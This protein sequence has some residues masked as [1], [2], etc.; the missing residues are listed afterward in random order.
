M[1]FVWSKCIRVVFGKNKLKVIFKSLTV[2]NVTVCVVSRLVVEL[3]RI[4]KTKGR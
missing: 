2:A 1:G 3:T 4:L